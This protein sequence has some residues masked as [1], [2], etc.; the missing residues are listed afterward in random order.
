MRC[1][2][3]HFYLQDRSWSDW[4]CFNPPKTKR[5]WLHVRRIW[6][7]THN[8][9]RT[10][11]LHLDQGSK[12]N[13]FLLKIFF[14]W[15]VFVEK[16][17]LISLNS[18]IWITKSTNKYWFENSST[19]S[20]NQRIKFSLICKNV[21]EFSTKIPINPPNFQRIMRNQWQ[22]SK[23]RPISN[24]ISTNSKI[25]WEFSLIRWNF[26]WKFVEIS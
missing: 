6:V 17:I 9:N 19:N 5:N 10:H 7:K 15:F 23:H 8:R 4:K 2:F 3:W 26:R 24:K 25:F 22:S 14:R 12:K 1:S 11:A 13:I 20:T 18:L 21:N 16:K